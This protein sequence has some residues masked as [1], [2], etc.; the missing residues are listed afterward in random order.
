M[1]SVQLSQRLRD[2]IVRA[3]EIELGKAYR[4]SYDVQKPL[5]TVLHYLEH[6]S[7]FLI[8]VIAMEKQYQQILPDLMRYYNISNIGYYNSRIKENLLK[9]NDR[10]GMVCNPNRP[11]EQNYQVLT[12]WNAPY[13]NDDGYHTE[14]E[15][16][17]NFE[18][19]DVAVL[20]KDINYYYPM[21]LSLDYQRGWR[22]KVYAPHKTGDGV[23]L[24]TDPELCQAFSPIGEI[25]DRI[26][27]E[28]Q[29]FKES[30]AKKNTLKQFLDDW[31]AGKSLVPQEDLARMTTVKKRTTP[32]KA[33]IDTIPEE[34]KD[35][36][37]E[38]ILGNKLLG[39]D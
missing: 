2:D 5:D 11:I 38:V 18:P 36:M 20:I 10:I 6:S 1:A 26:A 30:L 28:S 35:S 31:P 37:N 23:L 9:P 22:D 34:L 39:D 16:G 14:H 21:S 32:T 24:I 33:V 7:D 8:D 17:H 4:K 27:S 12:D 25:E 13:T 3:F 19:N 15:D 29:T